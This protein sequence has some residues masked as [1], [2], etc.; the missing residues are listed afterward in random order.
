M[1][2]IAHSIVLAKA[3]KW[4]NCYFGL[5]VSRKKTW[6]FFALYSSQGWNITQS[7]T[8][9]FI[10]HAPYLDFEISK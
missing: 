7:C 9:G 6:L 10:I 4:Y 5:C 1:G 2:N 3:G 8:R